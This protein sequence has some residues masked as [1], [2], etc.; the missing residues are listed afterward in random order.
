MLSYNIL[1]G[2]MAKIMK[3]I[4]KINYTAPIQNKRAVLVLQ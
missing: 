1:E 2:H 4:Y 3:K